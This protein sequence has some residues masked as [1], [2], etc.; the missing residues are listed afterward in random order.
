MVVKALA[1]AN[2]WVAMGIGLSSP[3]LF[4]FRGRCKGCTWHFGLTGPTRFI[5]ATTAHPLEPLRIVGSHASVAPR[6]IITTLVGLAPLM[7]SNLVSKCVCATQC[8]TA[9]ATKW[10]VRK[11]SPHDLRLQGHEILH[12]PG[13]PNSC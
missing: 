11:C 1:S 3:T 10:I 9:N 2:A 7:P 12:E 4:L 13:A 5:A 8:A 6:V